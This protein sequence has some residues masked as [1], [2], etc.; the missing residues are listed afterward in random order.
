MTFEFPSTVKRSRTSASVTWP[1]WQFFPGVKCKTGR[2]GLQ[3]HTGEVL[4]RRINIKELPKAS[5]DPDRKAAE[6]YVD[7]ARCSVNH[8]ESVFKAA[9]DLPNEAFRLTKVDLNGCKK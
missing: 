8:Q 3:Q 2:I 7:S 9:A 4:Y 1:K 5:A 6:D